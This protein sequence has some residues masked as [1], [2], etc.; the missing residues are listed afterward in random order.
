VEHRAHQR[1]GEVGLEVA[2]VIPAECGDAIAGTDTEGVERAGQAARP[3][4]A[5]G[6]G[7]AVEGV[8]GAAAHDRSVAE[9]RLRPRAM[10]VTVRGSPW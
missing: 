5:L 7:G 3:M 4:Q 8:V 10:A 6:V 1:D 9:E 2:V